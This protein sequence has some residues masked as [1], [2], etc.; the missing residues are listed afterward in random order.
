MRRLWKGA[1]WALVFLAL[2]LCGWL[3]HSSWTAERLK[4]S[5]TSNLAHWTGG[6]ARAESL[7]L[8][9][10]SGEVIVE[11][12][13]LEEG[14]G[15]L[16]GLVLQRAEVKLA[17]RPLLAGRIRPAA[18][19]LEGFRLL[20][21]GD[22]EW[23][24][25]E[26]A[27]AFDPALL[28][29]LRRLEV[30]GGVLDYHDR[31]I[32]FDLS[33]EGLELGGDRETGILRGTTAARS[34]QLRADNI[35]PQTLSDLRARWT[36]RSPRLS[37][38]E[39]SARTEAGEGTG[40][41]AFGLTPRGAVLRGGFNGS[42]RLEAVVDPAVIEARGKVNCRVSLRWSSP[43]SWQVKGDWET[44]GPARLLGLE[45][46][47]LGGKFQASTRH[48]DLLET[49]GVTAGGSRLEHLEVHWV[50]PSLE[51]V[52]R[53][54]ALL[55]E[56]LQRFGAPGSWGDGPVGFEARAVRR[57]PDAPF[58]WE[59]EGDLAVT[60]GPAEGVSGHY[61]VRAGEREG[62]ADFGGRWREAPLNLAAT[63]KGLFPDARW[64]LSSTLAGAGPEAAE[65]LFRRAAEQVRETPNAFPENLFPIPAEGLD[66]EFNLA[67]LGDRLGEGSL[68]GNWRRPAWA[69]EEFETFGL[70]L[71]FFETG[72][73]E[74]RFNLEGG[75]GEGLWS[76]VKSDPE[77][78]LQ[79]TARAARVPGR[80]L[81]HL[82][83]Q[84]GFLDAPLGVTGWLS[85][86]LTGT[87][88]EKGRRRLAFSGEGEAATARWPVTAFRG[89][90][91]LAG[92]WLELEG[93]E[94]GGAGWKAA[95]EGRFPLA[96]RAETGTGGGALSIEADLKQLLA[97]HQR[98]G[99]GKLRVSGR[100]AGWDTEGW[101]ILSGQARWTGVLLEGLVLA[102]GEAGIEPGGPGVA[103][104]AKL[105]PCGLA[106]HFQG[107]FEAP[108]FHFHAAWKQ[109]NLAEEAVAAGNLPLAMEG[110]S[111][112]QVEIEGPLLAPDLWTGAL[113]LARLDL[114]GPTFD[115]RLEHPARAI[116]EGEGKWQF[117]PESA[118]LIR[119]ESG[120]RMAIAGWFAPW[121]NQAGALD[122][123]LEGSADLSALEVFDPDLVASGTLSGR[124]L[125]RGT[126]DRPEVT[127]F[128]SLT[129]GRA[130]YL[131]LTEAA[132]DLNGEFTLTQG[133]LQIQR[134]SGRFGGGFLQAKGQ[135]QFSGWFPDRFNLDLT[136]RNVALSRPKGLTGRYD[137]SLALAGTLD[138]PQLRGTITMLAGRWVRP[139]SL[140]SLPWQRG[141]T[142][143]PAADR[144]WLSR[145]A[146]RLK[147]DGEGALAVRND[148]ARVEASLGLEVTGTWQ[149]PLLAGTVVLAQ[150]G[151]ITFRDLEY[152]VQAGQIVFDDPRGLPNRLRLVADTEINPYRI[153][154]DL[155]ATTEKVDYQLSSSPALAQADILA[156]LLTGQTGE[157]AT[158]LVSSGN[159]EDPA[160]LFGS[161][162]GELILSGPARR[163]LGLTRFQLSPVRAG[164]DARPTARITAGRRVGEKTTVIYSR[165][166]SGEGRD[167]YWV[168]RE[169]GRATRLSLG[170]EEL[171]GISAG[172][173]W[174]Y[175]FGDRVDR[176]GGE[177]Q[178]PPLLEGVVIEG[179]PAGV[180]VRRRT[181]LGLS[182]GEPVT[183]S[184]TARA[185]EGLRRVLI[186]EG[187]TEARVIPS[188]GVQDTA[189][190]PRR[191][192]LFL[193]VEPG[194]RWEID[195][196]APAGVS[197]LVQG[198]LADLWTTTS[199]HRGQG[200]EIA[201]VLRERLAEEAYAT[202]TAD[203]FE[204]PPPAAVLRLVVD[205]GP[206][207]RVQNL[208]IRGTSALSEAEVLGQVLTRP[209]GPLGTGRMLYRPRLVEEDAEAILTLYASKGF[210]EAK[211]EPEVGM[212]REGSDVHLVFRIVEGPRSQIGTVRVEGDWPAGLG[213]AS[214]KLGLRTG[215]HYLPEKVRAAEETLRRALDQAG[216]YEAQVT[217]RQ[218]ALQGKVNLTFRVLP[219][220]AARVAGIRLEGLGTTRRKMAERAVRLRPGEPLTRT[221]WR[222][223]ERELFK[224]G[225]FR[226]VEIEAV[227]APDD[228]GQ[229]V[230]II[231]VEEA[232]EV[233]LQTGIAYD[234]EQQL[235]ANATLSHDNLW[236]LGRTGS[237]QLFG[238]AL[239]RGARVTLEDRHLAQERW[240]GLLT[241]GFFRE[242]RDGF[243]V[244]S[245]GAALQIGS[246]PRQD[247]RWQLRY[248]LED[249][250]F[251]DVTIDPAALSGVEISDG[252]RVS[253][254]RLGSL[255]GSLVSD[256]RDDPFLPAK[257]WIGRGEVGIW[258]E[259]LASEASFV[260]LTGQWGGYQPLGRV[261]L[262]GA[263]RAS[264]AWPFGGTAAVPLSQRFFAG[265]SQTL[266]GFQR[267]KVGP[268]DQAGGQALGGEAL[269]LLNLESRLRILE[270]LD[271]VLFHDAGNV[272][273]KPRDLLS[274]PLRRSAGLGVRWRTPVGALRIEYGRVLHPRPGEG[275]GELFFSLGEPF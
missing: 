79:L 274:T 249:N 193:A 14:K 60:R 36:W 177:P 178:P 42:G 175:R 29:D 135:T 101:P 52:A 225:L 76:T 215:D 88:G 39:I 114:I 261:T 201:R 233:A 275:R 148:L 62:Q 226:K 219:G 83:F 180:R 217:S 25:S 212:R 209:G 210:L 85:G 258:A 172:L 257:G 120:A 44:A 105:G 146:L 244:E 2:A 102:D 139:F 149:Q 49:S 157:E 6:R 119:G 94:A 40:S 69:E 223:T 245:L 134:L 111:D 221:G 142:L 19:R 100:L 144:S 31:E 272:W 238:S 263:A 207:A 240:E 184:V 48:Y 21:R 84:A 254:V 47:A 236:G 103:L 3:L 138:E 169:L 86:N 187:Y 92:D 130:R 125:V 112:G 205:P 170:R 214:E 234:S 260:S 151:R 158:G 167:L 80:L 55:E 230:V 26:D 12:L 218:E 211:V 13:T 129:G 24:V 160:A 1:A 27:G 199:F 165:D 95:L 93:G 91:T 191:G 122:L 204:E 176:T 68:R 243:T 147:I 262:A 168:E 186:E 190:R 185:E 250:R 61:L 141:R 74:A 34:V 66:L 77:G 235:R 17:R 81:D 38:E 162:L 161:E 72:G 200:R 33:A 4:E 166:L 56:L 239:R 163:I 20:L 253:A 90:G 35:L 183:R 136:A 65:E 220:R 189:R 140:T 64:E 78:P 251:R 232:P 87:W 179:L 70:D 118:L 224:L 128:G 155:E 252:Q 188:V 16:S 30:S 197:A 164:S 154:L 268:L 107:P 28:D 123:L 255:T 229:R 50:R 206:L 266:R 10:F 46:T 264:L 75:S 53:G 57:Q 202:A 41:L 271:L 256:R 109:W 43:G 196:Q 113:D 145:L 63:W 156:L 246:P 153:R 54:N 5:L 98:K 270:P 67:G 8:R 37:V 73:M 173:R 45:F 18:L 259:P 265:G 131:T 96:G 71:R 194:P 11:N 152:E 22:S 116:L 213:A 106:A 181:D 228:P 237:L 9:L 241:A 104:R 99:E 159:E 182:R 208:E 198:A 267:D 171:G 195:I 126:F 82:A 216:Y 174:L 248:T 59:A 132:E 133:L 108:R 192:T 97:A 23:T 203:V 58:E 231:R 269:F 227:P 117:P 121:G 51:V 124:I 7:K 137:A 115:A 32:P 242:K 222:E 110:W 89:R 143:E 127:G 15:V 150:G 273:L 247:R